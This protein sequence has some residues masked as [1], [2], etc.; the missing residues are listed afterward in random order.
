M[1]RRTHKHEAHL[2]LVR[3]HV[4]QIDAANLEGR[5]GQHRLV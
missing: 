5:I 3:V 4:G 1:N 2:D